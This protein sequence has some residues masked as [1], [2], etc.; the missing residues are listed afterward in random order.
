MS[1]PVVQSAPQLRVNDSVDGNMLIDPE[2]IQRLARLA[3]LA[4]RVSFPYNF[5]TLRRQPQQQQHLTQEMPS[6]QR[7][8]PVKKCAVS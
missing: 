5:N 4:R 1:S 2:A 7:Q 6:Q 3:R 8:L